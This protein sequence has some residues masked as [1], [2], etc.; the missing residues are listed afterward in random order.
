MKLTEVFRLFHTTAFRIAMRYALI[1]AVLC[2]IVL[3]IFFWA[4]SVYVDAQLKKGLEDDFHSLVLQHESEGLSSLVD[5]V[6]S[7]SKAALDEGRF[8]LLV[9]QNENW[10]AG[11][12]QG[13]PPEDPITM[14]GQI[15]VMWVEDDIIPVASYTDDAYWPVIGKILPDGSQLVVA[16]SISQSE[17]MQ[18]YSLYALTALFFIVVSLALAMGLFIGRNILGRIDNITQTA[19]DIM[20]GD[21]KQ[22]MQV[23]P[24]NDEFDELSRQLNQMLERINDLIKGIREVTD[25]V[26]HDLRSPLTRIRNR[27]EVTLL[28]HRHEDE[29]R[30]EMELAIQDA[31]A[32]IKTF[33]AILQ[34]AQADAGHTRAVM[35]LVNITQLMQKMGEL[36]LPLAEE[37]NH[38]LVVNAKEKV[39]ITCDKD[40]VAQAVSNLLD[41]AIKYTPEG[42]VITL[43]VRPMDNGA[44]ISVG[45]NGP[46]IK[47][48]DRNYV[49]ER[50][51]RLDQARNKEGNGLGL[52]IVDSIARQHQASLVLK[53]NNPGLLAEICFKQ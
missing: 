12:L 45:D 25:N 17:D 14:D 34:I 39:V 50:F 46:G 40:L 32:L 38:K 30:E 24:G 52:S 27:L 9:D 23:G 20:A 42:G 6:A 37:R 53:D 51:T 19:Q 10:L 41:N 31:D 35:G 2:G 22:R 16:R 33:N 29:Y 5:L 11:N 28:E 1:Y 13:L 21:L 7:R 44:C 3:G 43:D 4:T 47:A 15:H 8:Y 36:Y 18:M 26:A 48:G 49:I